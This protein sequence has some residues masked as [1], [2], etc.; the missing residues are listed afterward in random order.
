MTSEYNDAIWESI[1]ATDRPL[2][3]RLSSRAGSFL[4][5]ATAVLDLGCG[6]GLY[7]PL[8]AE[9]CET[10]IGVDRSA[11]AL[12]KAVTRGGSPQLDRVLEDERLPLEDN[13]VQRIWCVDTLEHVVDTQ[14]VLSDARRVLEPGGQILIATPAHPLRLRLKLAFSGWDRHFDPFSPHLRFYTAGSLKNALNDT[15]FAVTELSSAGDLLVAKAT[16]T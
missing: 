11:V 13:C 2:D 1:P 10:V 16:R 14:I 8:L 4:A 9:H 15:G 12:Q 3:P 5:G 7:L 6:D